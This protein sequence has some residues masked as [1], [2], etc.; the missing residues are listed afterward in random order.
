MRAAVLTSYNH[1]EWLE[2]KTPQINEN[3]VL[4]QVGK[5][6]ICGSDQHIFTG[7]FHPRTKLPLI[8]GHEFAGTIVEVGKNIRNFRS[9]DRVAIDPLQPCGECG[10]CKRDHISA[11]SSVSLTGVDRDGGFG[12][13]VKVEEHQLFRLPD[14]VPFSHGALAEVYGVAFHA[15][16][17]AEVKPGDSVVIW[18]T[19]KVGHCILQAVRTITDGP[20]YM[21]DIMESRLKIASENYDDVIP[22]SPKID[23]PVAFIKDATNGGVD[24]ALEVVGHE[25]PIKGW[26]NPV[27]GCIQSV[28]G[29][30]NICVLGLGDDPMPILM[31]DLIFGEKKL[32]ASR[33]SHGEM[34]D[35]MKH[36]GEGNLKPE[37]LISKEMHASKAQEAFA[38]LDAEPE[39][40]LKILLGFE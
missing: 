34:T 36:L 4:V 13:Y 1:L 17:R 24:V 33:V 22:I 11:C 16:R 31:K 28:R 27:A 21:V 19:G 3:E 40:Q 32:I 35:V 10:A 12:E 18:G 15:T 39:K 5:V 2:V 14:H 23:D 29:G 20:V 7:S 8:Q 30:G 26:P 25:H 6:S 38:L 9:G 37:I